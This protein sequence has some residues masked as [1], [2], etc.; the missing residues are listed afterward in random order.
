MVNESE[1]LILTWRIVRQPPSSAS[2]TAPLCLAQKSASARVLSDRSG[3]TDESG[4]AP[5]ISTSLPHETE[6]PSDFSLTSP[7]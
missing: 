4:Y 2:V 6:R 7:P 5:V 3:A 1:S